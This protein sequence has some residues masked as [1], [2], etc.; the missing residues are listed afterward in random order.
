METIVEH[1]V[2]QPV[3]MSSTEMSEPTILCPH[4][5][6]NVLIANTL[7]KNE[8]PKFSADMGGQPLEIYTL[9]SR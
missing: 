4:Q 2:T 3:A 1:R 7:V 8:M 9:G 5:K 6:K